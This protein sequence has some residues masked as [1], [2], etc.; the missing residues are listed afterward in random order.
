[1]RPATA[2]VLLAGLGFPEGPRWHDGR[3]WFSDMHHGVVGTVGLDGADD[4]VARVDDRP[5]GLGFLPDGTPLVVSADRK[6]VLRID[7]GETSVHA[8]LT[9]ADAAWLNDM[10]VDEHGRAWVDAIRHHEDAGGDEAIDQIL[11]VEPDGGWHIATERAL[12]PNGIVLAEGGRLLIH[13]STRRRKLLGWTVGEDGRLSDPFLW[14]ETGRWTPDGICL[15]AAGGIWAGALA[16]QHFVRIERG[17][18]VTD[19][20]GVGERWAIA[21]A[22]GG[23][24]GRTLFMTTQDRQ[25][26]EGF[27]EIG[28]VDVPAAAA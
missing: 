10:V 3:L 19:V 12:R 25:T 23:P 22:L 9:S 8:D 15:D 16:K 6:L 27:V 14:A 24:D 17:G 7:A 11:V 13:A 28:A 4:V 21:C 20:I 18:E 26:G 5:S 2:S 1:V